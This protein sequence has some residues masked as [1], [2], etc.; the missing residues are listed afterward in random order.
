MPEY[1]LEHLIHTALHCQVIMW[2][3]L[4][5]FLEARGNDLQQQQVR[6]VPAASQSIHTTQWREIV[7]PC[8]FVSLECPM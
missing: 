8:V 5:R 4:L 2:N 7:I 3:S 6:E 1:T